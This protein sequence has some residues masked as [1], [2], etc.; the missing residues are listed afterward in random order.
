MR[1]FVKIKVFLIVGIILL[2]FNCSWLS[3]ISKNTVSCDYIVEECRCDTDVI[4]NPNCFKIYADV[5]LF[6][7]DREVA[8]L[9]ENIRKNI[10][11]LNIDFPSFK[12]STFYLGDIVDFSN[13]EEKNKIDAMKEIENLRS[14]VGENYVRG[15][16]EIGS[17]GKIGE[18]R[19]TIYKGKI[20][21]LHGH[22]LRYF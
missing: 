18:N 7:G 16:H 1:S 17:F 2:I 15:N 14:A 13:A 6:G 20:L 11:H 3:I 10:E 22:N 4:N 5:H 12:E 9:R 8:G 21:F 19:Y